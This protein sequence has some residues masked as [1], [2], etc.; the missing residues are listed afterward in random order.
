M[1]KNAAK[2]V[3]DFDS[4]DVY[5][6]Q[7]KDLELKIAKLRYDLHCEKEARAFFENLACRTL[8]KIQPKKFD[9]TIDGSQGYD[10]QEY[11]NQRKEFELKEKLKAKKELSA[12]QDSTMDTLTGFVINQNDEIAVL[13]Q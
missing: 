13:K 11:C 9:K 3:L 8:D 5:F 6:K 10:Y 12:Y 4:G 7:H 2:K 1:G